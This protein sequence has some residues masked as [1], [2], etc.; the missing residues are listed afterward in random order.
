MK[1][2]RIIGQLEEV[3]QLM[4]LSSSGKFPNMSR[5]ELVRYCTIISMNSK[6]FYNNV[7]KKCDVSVGSFIYRNSCK[8]QATLDMEL[9]CYAF[10]LQPRQVAQTLKL[11]LIFEEVQFRVQ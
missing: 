4:Q 3:D 5:F 7:V 6:S 10:D 1:K 9:Y 2:M 8:E 11:H